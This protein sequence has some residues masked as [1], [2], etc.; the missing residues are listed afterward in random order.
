MRSVSF[1]L[2]PRGQISITGDKPVNHV[3]KADLKRHRIGQVE[4]LAELGRRAC[5]VPKAAN[6]YDGVADEISVRHIT[7]DDIDAMRHICTLTGGEIIKDP[8]RGAACQERLAQ[9]RANESRAASDQVHQTKLFCR[10][11]DSRRQPSGSAP[12]LS[13]LTARP[14]P[15]QPVEIGDRPASRRPEFQ[16]DCQN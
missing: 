3:G 14:V 6:S 8:H 7:H 1:M 4:G 16:A 12:S 9:M 10:Q 2:P 15:A 11:H 13:P 5:R